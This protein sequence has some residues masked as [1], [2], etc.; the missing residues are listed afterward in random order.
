MFLSS[1]ALIPSAPQVYCRISRCV[2]LNAEFKRFL[3]VSY[4]DVNNKN[5]CPNRD[6]CLMICSINPLRI[7][8]DAVLIELI[9]LLADLK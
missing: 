1:G 6:S 9:C 4:T 7:L 2:S 3:T 5:S 8:A